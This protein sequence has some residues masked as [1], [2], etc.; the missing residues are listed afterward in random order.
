MAEAVFRDLIHETGLENHFDIESAAVGS[1]EV[2]Q[3]PDPRTLEVLRRHNLKI[4]GKRARQVTRSDFGEFNYILAMDSENVAD[5]Q[6]RY[7]IGIP[8]LL[9]FAA[10]EEIHRYSK[11]LDVPDPYYI[12]GFDT[13]YNLVLIGSKGL[14][15]HIRIKE[16]L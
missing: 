15:A 3:R 7:G 13:V 16:G 14:L 1:W 12:G 2:G 10:R 11:G 8:R 4:D 6:A 9:E 5:I